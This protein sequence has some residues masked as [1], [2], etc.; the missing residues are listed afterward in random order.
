MQIVIYENAYKMHT[1]IF[2]P[3]NLVVQLF[4]KVMKINYT[5][6]LYIR[7][8]TKKCFQLHRF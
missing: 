4:I 8:V 1:I 5:N 2:V 6:K 3:Q 7:A